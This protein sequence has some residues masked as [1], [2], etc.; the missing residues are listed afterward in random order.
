MTE[1]EKFFGFKILE[2]L[3]DEWRD[4]RNLEFFKKEEILK[5]V[6]PYKPPFYKIE[7]AVFIPSVFK[8]KVFVVAEIGTAECEG[9][10]SKRPVIPYI[11]IMRICAQSGVL[12]MGVLLRQKEKM[13]PIVARSG[14]TKA[15]VDKFLKPPQKIMTSATIVGQRGVWSFV[16]TKAYAT[17]GGDKEMVFVASAEKIVYKL[18]PKENIQGP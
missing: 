7:Q 16:D 9:H 14:K 8:E 1:V 15:F 10:F 13:I 4:G 12:L 2:I 17:A 18:I 11:E 5:I 6:E 3:N